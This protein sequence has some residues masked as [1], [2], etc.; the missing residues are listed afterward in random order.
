MD[1]TSRAI[2][3]GTMAAGGI[4]QMIALL[5]VAVVEEPFPTALILGAAGLVLFIV[6]A[7]LYDQRSV[8]SSQNPQPPTTLE[9]F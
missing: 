6:G 9:G 1:H 4:M 5:V 7:A 3:I 8:R 2:S